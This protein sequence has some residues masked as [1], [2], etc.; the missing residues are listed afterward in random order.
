MSPERRTISFEDA[1]ALLEEQ[2]AVLL[3][4]AGENDVSIDQLA[5][6]NQSICLTTLT[7]FALD[8]KIKARGAEE[9][10]VKAMKITIKG[11]AKE[12]AELAIEVQARP[13][14]ENV[15]FQGFND[16]LMKD[17]QNPLNIVSEANSTE[18]ENTTTAALVEELKKREGVDTRI[19]E[20]YVDFDVKVNGPAI[21][22]IV[23]D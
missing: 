22:L 1:K 17:V 20:P 4:R 16:S 7:L 23:V 12:I 21:V 6:L 15:D 8:E 13:I 14:S 10:E 5:Q 11:S 2:F 18:L 3:E 19:V 9:S